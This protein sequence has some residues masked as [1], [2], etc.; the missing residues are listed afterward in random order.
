MQVKEKTRDNDRLK[1]Q[2]E[3]QN[4]EA[5]FW[6]LKYLEAVI[7]LQNANRGIARL[8]RGKQKYSNVD[9]L[10]KKAYDNGIIEGYDKGYEKA[11]AI[12]KDV[13]NRHKTA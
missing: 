5:D 3:Y 2:P 11:I 13:R 12:E 4:V 8:V 9:V 7:E 6:K 10:C 1:F